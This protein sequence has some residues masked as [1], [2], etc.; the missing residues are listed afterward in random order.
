MP[1]IVFTGYPSSGKTTRAK[2]LVEWISQ[3]IYSYNYSGP[4]HTVKHITD[5]DLGYTKDIYADPA[6]EKKAR[7]SMLSA[8]ERT[9]SRNSI[10]VADSLNYI[11]GF[12][13]QLYCVA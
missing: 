9:L 8:V 7:G 6:E 1:L 3:R 5:D 11:K 10:V 13:Y 4:I 2:E 12:R